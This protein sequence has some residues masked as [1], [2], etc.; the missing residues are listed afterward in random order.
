MSNA[1]NLARNASKPRAIWSDTLTKQHFDF[2]GNVTLFVAILK[3]SVSLR[4]TSHEADNIDEERDEDGGPDLCRKVAPLYDTCGVYIIDD[5]PI[6][7]DWLSV[8]NYL[9]RYEQNYISTGYIAR[10][11]AGQSQLHQQPSHNTQE[12]IKKQIETIEKNRQA[13][14]EELCKIHACRG[15]IEKTLVNLT[16]VLKRD[17]PTPRGPG[18]EYDL[19]LNEQNVYAFSLLTWEIRKMKEELLREFDPNLEGH[20]YDYEGIGYVTMRALESPGGEPANSL[21]SV[22]PVKK[23]AYLWDAGLCLEDLLNTHGDG[24][25]DGGHKE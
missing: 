3:H 23:S 10:W 2:N 13:A 7:E 11:I 9:S 22:K 16:E 8:R 4:A 18:D 6:K 19:V 12:M 24:R 20:D 21:S 14:F 25:K 15:K 5:E 17:Y 1:F